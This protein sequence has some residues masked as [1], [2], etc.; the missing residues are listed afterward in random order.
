[1][2]YTDI[3]SLAAELINEPIERERRLREVMNPNTE[4]QRQ[5]EAATAPMVEAQRQINAINEMYA[6]VRDEFRRVEQRYAPVRDE[7]RHV[8]EMIRSPIEQARQLMETIP[9]EGYSG[10]TESGLSMLDFGYPYPSHEE[11][12]GSQEAVRLLRE[13]RDDV[14]AI[15]RHLCDGGDDDL[16]SEEP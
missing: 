11:S 5:I 3:I 16:P 4:A 9:I 6:P 8:E 1:L 14:R 13:I 10:L 15:R 7:F 2:D 12:L